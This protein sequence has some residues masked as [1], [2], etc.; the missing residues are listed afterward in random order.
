[1][2]QQTLAGCFEKRSDNTQLKYIGR[3]TYGSTYDD[4]TTQPSNACSRLLSNACDTT[5]KKAAWISGGIVGSSLVIS[6]YWWVPAFT[7]AIAGGTK[8]ISTFN[9]AT[10]ATL[11]N[12]VL[13]N[14]ETFDPNAAAANNINHIA[15]N[16]DNAIKQGK[17]NWEARKK[18]KQKTRQHTQEEAQNNVELNE[19]YVVQNSQDNQD[20]WHDAQEEQTNS[21]GSFGSGESN[22]ALYPSIDSVLL[23]TTPA[24]QKIHYIAHHPV[25]AYG[26]HLTAG[27]IQDYADLDSQ[28]IVKILS[29]ANQ[30]TVPGIL[31]DV[32][33]HTYPITCIN[34][35]NM[36][37]QLA[38][39]PAAFVR[40]QT[41]NQVQVPQ[42]IITEQ[43]F[44]TIASQGHDFGDITH[45]AHFSKNTI[46]N[47]IRSAMANKLPGMLIHWG[48]QKIHVACYF[49]WEKLLQKAPSS[50]LINN[51]SNMF[52]VDATPKKQPVT[53]HNNRHQTSQKQNHKKQRAHS[54]TP[55]N[56]F[57]IS[58]HMH[59][60]ITPATQNALREAK[61]ILLKIVKGNRFQPRGELKIFIEQK[62]YRTY[63]EKGVTYL[64]LVTQAEAPIFSYYPN[65]AVA[66]TA[67]ITFYEGAIS[68][69]VAWNKIGLNQLKP[70]LSQGPTGQSFYHANKKFYP[71]E[72]NEQLTTTL[73]EMVHLLLPLYSLLQNSHYF[74]QNPYWHE[75][76]Q[77]LLGNWVYS[78]RPHG[79][80]TGSKTVAYF[81]Q[82]VQQRGQDPR[83]FDN[84]VP[85]DYLHPSS[86]TINCLEPAPGIF[87]ETRG[88]YLNR[89]LLYMLEDAGWILD[90]AA[91]EQYLFHGPTEPQ[92]AA[93]Q[94]AGL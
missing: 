38:N 80:F 13:P 4:E 12:L 24:W 74:R 34:T 58:L 42:N 53:S 16:V 18:K 51:S 78:R 17:K 30:N 39:D 93:C 64:D 37:Q 48:S 25:D 76:Y 75:P 73:H 9:N 65:S 90:M 63:T 84:G 86:D 2:P 11:N 21:H 55:N 29:F 36:F 23:D 83:R 14:P 7:T 77:N 27:N 41:A 79:F 45:Y 35:W 19:Q 94:R 43:N 50:T 32:Q 66:S 91:A 49:V 92:T 69:N 62:Q 6:G 22:Q 67:G 61:D 28:W 26:H 82:L 47:G 59:G 71:S 1:M 46:I 57:D 3:Y 68:R 54:T 10:D 40:F 72:A 8:A 44:A 85:L 15:N 87:G 52:E 5:L 89:G 33:G 81:K 88:P 56:S 70:Y 31:M 60:Q 20:V